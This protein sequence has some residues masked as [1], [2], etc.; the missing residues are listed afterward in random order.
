MT[1]PSQ[2]TATTGAA[3]RALVPS[4]QLLE[5]AR[6]EG[7]AVAALNFYN[8]ETLRAHI[9]AANEA[10]ASV[11]LQTTESTIKYLG[12]R[13]VVAMARAA[14]EEVERPVALH[15]DHGASYDL[16]ARCVEAGYT[17]VMIDGS[18]LP[19]DENVEVTRRVVEM[20]HAAGVSVE[21]ELG[22]VAHNEEGGDISRFY[23]RPDTASRFVEATGADA[24]AVAVGTA[25]GFYKGEVRLDF[26]RLG[27]IRD[28]VGDRAALVLHGGSGVPDELLRRAVS[29]GIRKINFG[30]EL[31]NAFTLA[32]R[33]SLSAGDEIDLRKTFAPAVEAVRGISS[34]KIRI[35]S[36]QQ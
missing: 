23:T 20:A 9:D 1:N 15:L 8:A 34:A 12:I 28:A 14:A 13:M 31:K 2:Q 29:C 22:H 16:A 24:L 10:G 25:H 4:R 36:L 30:T 27:Q 18:K 17:S 3:G 6:R 11:I 26:E 33:R 32:V 21:G 19:F 7:R 35:C 5:E